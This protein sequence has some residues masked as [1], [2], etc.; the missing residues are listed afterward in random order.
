MPNP[1]FRAIVHVHPLPTDSSYLIRRFGNRFGIPLACPIDSRR[2][3]TRLLPLYGSETESPPNSPIAQT[4][5]TDNGRRTDEESGRSFRPSR[6][7]P[8]CS[9]G[10][11]RADA[12][13]FTFSFSDTNGDAGNGTLVEAEA[14]GLGTAAIW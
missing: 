12:G 6:F 14:V 7:Q 4:P 10:V 3:F 1:Q 11:G 8:Y 2:L 9:C 5:S 13:Q